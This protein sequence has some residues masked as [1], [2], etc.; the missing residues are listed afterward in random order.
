MIELHIAKSAREWREAVLERDGNRCVSMQHAAGCGSILEAHH[1][2]YL[3]HLS[4]RALWIVE[5]G[6]TLSRECHKLAHLT[7][8]ISLG[9]V[10]ANA[11]VIAV[12]CVESI[13][14][15]RFT[16]KGIAA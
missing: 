5:N 13:P 10:R 4:E 7:H 2:V 6:F 16:K 11:A 12:N 14:V 1:C 3:V 8:N 9:L 15:P